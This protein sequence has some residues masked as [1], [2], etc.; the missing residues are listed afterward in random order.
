MQQL[1][2]FR[3]GIV[4]SC[5]YT[6]VIGRHREV[7]DISSQITFAHRRTA[8]QLPVMAE[9]WQLETAFCGHFAAVRHMQI[10]GSEF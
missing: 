5:L 6:V 9:C 3:H 2:P 8:V 7:L 4:R 10:G 1:A